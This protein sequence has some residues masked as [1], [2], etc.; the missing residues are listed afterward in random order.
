MEGKTE[1]VDCEVCVGSG[2]YF[3][4]DAPTLGR[5]CE[6]CISG[7]VLPESPT[8]DYIPQGQPMVWALDVSESETP[9][10]YDGEN[11]VG[12]SYILHRQGHNYPLNW[13]LVSNEKMI[14]TLHRWIS[15][16]KIPELVLEDTSAGYV[17]NESV[18]W[19]RIIDALGMLKHK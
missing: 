5:N 15:E 2:Y 13:Y 6:F 11:E 4:D 17:S 16:N 9:F 14:K 12:I 1:A 3:P 18:A 10:I 7:A 19:K 8:D